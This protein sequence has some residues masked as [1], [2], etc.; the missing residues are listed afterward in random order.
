M[1]KT[2][3]SNR[4]DDT[5]FEEKLIADSAYELRNNA[6]KCVYCFSEY[7]A[8]EIAKRVQEIGIICIITKID[9]MYSVSLE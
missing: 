1:R 6:I 2:R 8:K 9:N 4:N 5:D 7:Q 3:T